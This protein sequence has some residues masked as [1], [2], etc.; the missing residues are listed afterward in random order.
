MITQNKYI[1]KYSICGEFTC[2]NNQ[3]I[4]H[5]DNTLYPNVEPIIYDSN[6]K[7]LIYIIKAEYYT[8]VIPNKIVV[9]QYKYTWNDNTFTYISW[10]KVYPTYTIIIDV[11][12]M[13]NN[14]IT[15]KFNN[16]ADQTI[17]IS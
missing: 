5:I 6:N 12:P 16:I 7:I 4:E 15:Y 10:T 3:I 14:M 11:S 2:A 1:C 9:N 8:Q 17:Q 13:V